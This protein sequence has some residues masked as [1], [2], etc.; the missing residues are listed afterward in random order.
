MLP[1]ST[2]T[3]VIGGSIAGL[4]HALVLKSLGRNVFILEARSA[5]E[6]QARAAGLSLLPHAQELITK[7][8]PSVD[9]DEVA[10]RNRF[11]QIMNGDGVI[12]TELPAS[13]DI[14]TS[15]WGA[16]HSLLREACEDSHGGDGLVIF[17]M[18]H[19]VCGIGEQGSTVVVTYS[20]TDGIEGRI[21]ASLVI[22]ADG[23]RSFVRSLLMP[24]VRSEY[25][26]YVA[27]RGSFPETDVPS[28]LKGVL[29]GK[30]LMC[31]FANSYIFAYLTPDLTGSTA[32]GNRLMEW[33]WYDDYEASS[34]YF[35]DSMTDANGVQHNHTV[36]AHLLRRETWTTQLARR[37]NTMPSLWH[38]LL[39]STTKDNL[40]LLTAICS[41]DNTTAAFMGGKVML[42]GEAF[43]QLRPHR[44][45]SCSIPALQ[46]LRLAQVPRGG[47]VPGDA[48]RE[49]REY[50][51]QQSL[52]SKAVGVFGMTGKWP[53]GYVPSS[54]AFLKPSST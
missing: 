6:L 14:C 25:A 52:S 16:I 15:S 3:I 41:F 11:T 35:N 22:A 10:F 12:L 21:R 18:S 19:R 47:R 44:G 40:P 46:A 23:A 26:G 39:R 2:D 45:A 29:D 1:S 13:E 17:G 42:A 5:D 32:P 33:C 9:L 37:Q 36:S 24:E 30:L 34:S 51:T 43:T 7:Y 49:V 48:E 54:Y 8:A 28:E 27:W 50:V 20:G 4:M 53:E 38:Q 31:S